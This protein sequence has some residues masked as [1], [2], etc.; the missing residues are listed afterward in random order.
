M[1]EKWEGGHS[2]RTYSD[3]RR[4]NSHF[5]HLYGQD[6]ICRVASKPKSHHD[7]VLDVHKG[8]E[9]EV[10]LASFLPDDLKWRAIPARRK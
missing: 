10:E 6:A 1:R 7:H 5:L 2:D 3:R 4:R 9:M 8:A